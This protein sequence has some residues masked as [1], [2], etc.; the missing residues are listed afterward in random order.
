[1]LRFVTFLLFSVVICLVALPSYADISLSLQQGRSPRTGLPGYTGCGDT[2][3]NDD[4]YT[5]NYGNDWDL[6]AEDYGTTGQRDFLIRFD[7]TSVLPTGAN[8]QLASLHAYFWDDYGM[9]GDDYMNLGAYRLKV[10]WDEGTGGNGTERTGASWRYRYGLPNNTTWNADGA[11]GTGDRY[12]QSDAQVVV[13]AD[14]YGWK[15]WS[16]PAIVNTVKTWQANAAQNFGWVVDVDYT[17]DD[18]NRAYFHSSEYGTSSAD[19]IW[20]PKLD[21]TYTLQPEADADGPYYVSP[22]ESDLLDGTAS[23]DPDGENIV[24]WLWDLDDDQDYDDASGATCEVTYDYLVN[25]LGLIPGHVYDIG[26]KVVDDEGE[27]GFASSSID[28]IPEPSGLVLLIV[29]AMLLA[30]RRRN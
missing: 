1:M 28:L 6:F 12:S 15:T 19:Y 10:G 26:L 20:R 14:Q 13:T 17:N 22:S 29:G 16:G 25:T 30:L 4:D 24:S 21:I 3:L 5:E 18:T 11:R 23:Y 2:Y 7:L 8:V 27:C 9:S